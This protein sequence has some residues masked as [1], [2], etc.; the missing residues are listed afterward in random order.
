MTE[1]SWIGKESKKKKTFRVQIWDVYKFS[2]MNDARKWEKDT[3]SVCPDKMRIPFLHC[4]F[5]HSLSPDNRPNN[6]ANESPLWNSIIIWFNPIKWFSPLR[7]PTFGWRLNQ[8]SGPCS[9]LIKAEE[10]SLNSMKMDENYQH[11]IQQNQWN[12]FSRNHGSKSQ[13]YRDHQVEQVNKIAGNRE[14]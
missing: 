10:S 11:W 13:W 2:I 12:P 1:I 7:N 4:R 9:L 5:N 3:L 6:V 14:N 8:I